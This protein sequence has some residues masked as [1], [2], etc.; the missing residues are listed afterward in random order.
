MIHQ[1]LAV[2]NLQCLLSNSWTLKFLRIFGLGLWWFESTL[3][4]CCK[5]N[6][7]Q[8]CIKRGLKK[9]NAMHFESSSVVTLK[10][11]PRYRI[12]QKNT[13]HNKK[14]SCN[15]VMSLSNIALREN[16]CSGNEDMSFESV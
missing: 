1:T 2:V 4:N 11:W 14:Y 8:D 5:I 16:I 9:K 7:R 3:S 12:I 13:R 6:V 10:G 15:Y